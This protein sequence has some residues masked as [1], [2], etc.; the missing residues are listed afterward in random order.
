MSTISTAKM[1][2]RQFLE[3][4]EDP[5]GVR[6]E[7]VDGEVA[8]SPSAT[9]N[10]S[11][12]EKLLSMIL[13]NHVRNK[14]LGRLYGN[15]D[16]IFGRHDVRRPDL[17]FF[18]NNRLDLV[19]KK[20]MEGPPDLCVE[21]VSPSS[22]LIDR[23]DKFK[24]YAKGKVAYYWIVDPEDRTAEAFKLVR[25]DYRPAGAGRE[26]DIVKFPPFLDLKIPLGEIWQPERTRPSVH[27]NS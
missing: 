12:T 9:P 21:I 3:L 5:V 20:A 11:Y 16:T 23:R 13:V 1:T 10:H 25:R 14:K 19:G 18:S 24:Q 22:R 17:I 4:G 8:V 7:L 26:N 2:A 6:L 15:V 27:R